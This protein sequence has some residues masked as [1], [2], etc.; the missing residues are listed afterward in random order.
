MKCTTCGF[1]YEGEPICPIC[2]TLAPQKET[3]VPPVHTAF[4]E[5]NPY[6]SQPNAPTPKST[7]PTPPVLPRSNREHHHKPSRALMIV[8]VILLSVTMAASC[9][10]AVFTTMNYFQNKNASDFFG[11]VNNLIETAKNYFKNGDFSD[12][13]DSDILSELYDDEYSAESERNYEYIDDDTDRTINDPFDF[14]YGTITAIS[15]AATGK[16][17]LNDSDMIQYAFTFELKN[18]TEKKITYVFP[19]L[20]IEDCT[21]LYSESSV[22]TA[23][24]GNKI[25]LDAGDSTTIVYYFNVPKSKVSVQIDC[26]IEDMKS[27][28]CANTAFV[29]ELPSVQNKKITQ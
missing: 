8:L 14:R 2:G 9:V 24:D 23:Y 26:D 20:W 27:T 3:P 10:T 25:I 22:E 5:E 11:M 16:T 29:I 21:E 1:D 6:L 12:F 13:A 28:F 18:S 15:S 19:Y 17:A 7:L 4:T